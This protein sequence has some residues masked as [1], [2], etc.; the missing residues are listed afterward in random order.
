MYTVHQIAY[1]LHGFSRFT[2]PPP[3]GEEDARGGIS[4]RMQELDY[5]ESEECISFEAAKS[6]VAYLLAFLPRSAWL[7][8][9]A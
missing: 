7:S 9:P 2:Y 1:L 6:H 3:P 5:V 4:E 8:M